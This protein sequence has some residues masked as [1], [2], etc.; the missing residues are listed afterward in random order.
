MQSL[1]APLD[2][3]SGQK[4]TYLKNLRLITKNTGRLL[5]FAG[6]QRVE[7][8]NDDFFG[9]GISPEDA[10]PEHLFR[11]AANSRIGVFASQLGLIARLGSKYPRVPYLIKLNAKTNLVDSEDQDPYSGA[12][13]DVRD[14]AEFAKTSKLTIPAVGYTV[15]VGSRYEATMLREAAQVVKQAH[16]LGLVAVL[17][18]YPRGAAIANKYDAHLIAGAVNVGASL[19]ADFVKVNRPEPSIDGMKEIVS[20]AAATRVIFA[21]GNEMPADTLIETVYEHIRHGAAGAAL[22][23]NLHQRPLNEAIG[24]ANALASVIYDGQTPQAASRHAK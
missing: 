10:S 19:G 13:Y 7:H 23:R 24:L 6:D 3:P 14:V 2:V 11:I 18:M 17:W 1:A 16:Q 5:L 9:A 22:G 15:Y 8:L 4:S 21:G 20:A 12:W